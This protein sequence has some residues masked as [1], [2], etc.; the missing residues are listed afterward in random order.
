MPRGVKGSGP[1]S[2]HPLPPQAAEPAPLADEPAG[3]DAPP[4]P[5]HHRNNPAKLSGEALRKLGHQWGLA[6]SQMESMD[7]NKLRMQLAAIA[8]RRADERWT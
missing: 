8:H 4:L 3:G 1:F 6:W 2:K 5:F 7:D